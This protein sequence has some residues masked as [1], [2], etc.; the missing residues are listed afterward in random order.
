MK[1]AT[2]TLADL[3]GADVRYVV[4][5]YQRPYVWKKETHWRPLWEDVEEVVE[6]Q[7]QA[8]TN[9]ASHFLGA[10]V[11]EQRDTPPGEASR[12]LVIDGQQRLTTLQLLL[13][14]A[15]QE[16]EKAGAERE[17]R[18]L[19]RLTH[20][21]EDLTSGDA[22]FKVW[23]T[24]ANQKAFRAV[25]SGDGEGTVPDD[26]GNT[27]QEA[28][29]FFRQAIRAWSR[30][31]HPGPDELLRRFEA[32]R[33]GLDSLL[34]I[35]S[36]NLEHG[37]N[38]QVIFETLNARGT[39]LLAM[40][41]VKNALFYRASLAGIETDALHDNIWEPQ[42]GQAYWREPKRQGRLNRPRAELFLMHWLAMKLGRIVAATELFSE[43]RAHILD[44]T[45]PADMAEL[46]RELCD[47]AAVMRSFDDQPPGSIEERFFRHLETLDTTTVLPV[48][49]LLYSSI[50]VEPEVRRRALSAIESWLVRRMLS[51][52]TTK[53]YNNVGAALLEAARRDLSRADEEIVDELASADIATQIWP[54]DAEVLQLLLTRG[55]YGSVAQRRVVMLLA[56]VELERRHA[57]NKTENVFTLPEK[58]TVEHVMPQKWRDHWP[59]PAE[60]E[61]DSAAVEAGRDAVLHRL[62]NLTLTSGPLN[63]SLSNGPWDTKRAALQNHSLLLL[64]S[65]LASKSRWEVEDINRRGYAM[66]LE[67]CEIWPSPEQFQGAQADERP[68]IDEILAASVAAATAGAGSSVLA[69]SLGDLIRAE[70]IEEGESLYSRRTTVLVPAVV[71]GDGRLEVLEEVFD[72]PSSAACRAAGT[73]AENGWDFWAV[74]RDGQRLA[75]KDVRT[76]FMGAA[77]GG[78]SRSLAPRHE[79][80][81][82]FW[83]TLLDLAGDRSHPHVSVS[84]ST[85][86]W[87]GAGSGRSGVHF[88]YTIRQEDSGAHL[89][90]E[91]SDAELNARNFEALAI[92]REQIES[93]FG[94]PLDWDRVEGRKRCFVGVTLEGGGYTADRDRWPE[95]QQAMLDAML[96]LDAVFRPRIQTL[97]N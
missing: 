44:K 79:S 75:L 19:R 18:L 53:N 61:T 12:R 81:R 43:F 16:A 14:A 58:L 9:P 20:N 91:S 27:V 65:E 2:H 37:D 1:P 73:K 71:L 96:R 4:P 5:L 69:V 23:P 41:L 26:P 97:S 67:I 33:I 80:R 89:V 87:L 51:G 88:L 76:Q 8:A 82:L 90:F 95:I 62:G 92:E 25:M 21:D 35:V 55:L 15:A 48:A 84:P 52:L 40:D 46:V 42:L 77:G 66:G 6:R 39:P 10:V 17:S 59:V 64:N 86:S 94:G 28:H 72:S 11:L 85:D 78:G 68:S 38:A 3:F 70:L 56:A 7:L 54:R 83:A 49:L 74:E 60:D 31:D 57:N 93:E 36:I 32:L 13:A 34:Q 22:R 30:Q 63:S 24:N 47:H 45:P 50:E 29:S